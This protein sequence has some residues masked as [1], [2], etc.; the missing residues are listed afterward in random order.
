VGPDR[1]RIKYILGFY[2]TQGPLSTRSG[3]IKGLE[4]FEMEPTQGVAAEAL[5][6]VLSAL[7]GRVDAP[8]TICWADDLI[9]QLDEPPIEII[10]LALVS[11]NDS[12]K[13]I[14]ALET[15]AYPAGISREL[16]VLLLARL[17]SELET[18]ILSAKQ[19]AEMLYHLRNR[20]PALTS[21]E[22][23]R[24]SVVTDELEVAER[25]MGNSEEAIQDLA[26]SL[27]RYR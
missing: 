8:Q 2:R 23:V 10:D 11:P 14:A 21:Q 18:G 13:L 26:D 20:C 1:E 6:L 7:I 4:S 9:R 3:R 17:G 25:Y 24:F 19:V 22:W 5:Y 15:L 12:R 27:A 16:T